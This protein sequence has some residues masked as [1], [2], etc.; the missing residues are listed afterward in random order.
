MSNEESEWVHQ[1][2]RYIHSAAL[3]IHHDNDFE[4]KKRKRVFKMSWRDWKVSLPIWQKGLLVYEMRV[5]SVAL[6]R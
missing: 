2:V 4:A 5:S 6:L 1:V 3:F